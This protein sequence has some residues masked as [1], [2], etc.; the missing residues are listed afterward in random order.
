MKYFCNCLSILPEGVLTP[1]GAN[2]STNVRIANRIVHAASKQFVPPTVAPKQ[3]LSSFLVEIVDNTKFDTVKAL[4]VSGASV[5]TSRVTGGIYCSHVDAQ[6]AV[7]KKAAIENTHAEVISTE[8]LYREEQEVLQGNGTIDLSKGVWF[9][10]YSIA[11]PPC[12]WVHAYGMGKEK[13]G[14]VLIPGK[15]EGAV[16]CSFLYVADDESLSFWAET[17]DERVTGVCTAL[18]II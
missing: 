12:A 16:G 14:Q 10:T 18:R 13:V 8:A 3:V 1:N 5:V 11:V 17:A 15:H 9:I 6:T 4:N 7:C 2:I